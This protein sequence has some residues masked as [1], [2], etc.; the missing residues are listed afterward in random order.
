MDTGSLTKY[1]SYIN[2]QIT[3][4]SSA[5]GQVENRKSARCL[6]GKR[7]NSRGKRLDN[8]RGEY[9]NAVDS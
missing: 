4:R 5:V 3:Y 6:R 8:T 2:A 1:T 9:N 7:G